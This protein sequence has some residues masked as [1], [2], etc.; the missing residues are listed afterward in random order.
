[1]K[2]FG[3]LFLRDVKK[4]GIAYIPVFLG[5]LAVCASFLWLSHLTNQDRVNYTRLSTLLLFA[6]LPVLLSL[7][8]SGDSLAKTDQ[9]WFSLP[10]RRSTVVMSRVL[11]MLVFLSISTVAAFLWSLL[12]VPV[13]IHQMEDIL[14][15][16]GAGANGFEDLIPFYNDYWGF[17]FHQCRA[18]FE[19]K[20]FALF[21]FILMG[22][23][24]LTQSLKYSLKW[25]NGF[26]RNISVFALFILFCRYGMRGTDFSR[27]EHALGSIVFGFFVG[28]ALILAGFVIFDKAAEV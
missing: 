7:S 22:A 1:M 14:R 12:M 24:V 10:L 25:Y 16:T 13:E 3:T 26:L 27:G 8:F 5:W 20:I 4:T 28:A 11:S 21:S 19:T 17:Y 23:I 9:Q 18:V 2:M 6:S 15:K